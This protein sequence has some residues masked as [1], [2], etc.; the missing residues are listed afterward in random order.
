MAVNAGLVDTQAN[1]GVGDA[2]T[3][4]LTPWQEYFGAPANPEVR[5]ENVLPHET[6]NLPK[7]YEGR[8]LYLMQ[9]IEKLILS[10]DDWYTRRVLPWRRTNE[11][12]I[13]WD[14]WR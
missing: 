3:K 9:T 6:Y 13:K 2:S 8:N 14:I 12:H 5:A 10:T 4:Q 1:V 11:L 7:S